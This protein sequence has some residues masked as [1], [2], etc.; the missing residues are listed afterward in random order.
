MQMNIIA[1]KNEVTKQLSEQ[2]LV[3]YM[4]SIIPI[5]I[6]WQLDMIIS[7]YPLLELILSLVIAMVPL[8]IS[9]IYLT[10]YR[11]H[12]FDFKR[13]VIDHSVDNGIKYTLVNLGA[14]FII[15]FWSLLFVVPGIIKQYAYTFIPYIAREEP[16]A[17]FM[18]ILDKSE[19]LTKGHKMTIFKIQLRYLW[20]V[21]LGL[22]I[23]VFSLVGILSLLFPPFS[24]ISFGLYGALLYPVGL[25]LILI[26]TVYGMPRFEIAKVVMY[27]ELTSE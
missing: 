7:P 1:I 12:D 14:G 25:V 15:L 9:N 20:L 24:A 3:M 8:V 11:G 10:L 19:A 17:G 21:F 16:D 13:D 26:G 18:E 27:E 5:L 22:I 4:V 2:R 23:Q 6:V